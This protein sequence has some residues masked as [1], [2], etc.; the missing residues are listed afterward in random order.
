MREAM[1]EA[2]REAVAAKAD[3]RNTTIELKSDI[4]ELA[5]RFSVLTWMV[6]INVALSLGVLGKLLR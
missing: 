2:L 4:R 1:D 3:L 6:G 5:T